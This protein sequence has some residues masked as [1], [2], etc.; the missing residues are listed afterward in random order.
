MPEP[1]TLKSPTPPSQPQEQLSNASARVAPVRALFW[2]A[3]LSV[4]MC[5]VGL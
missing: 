3:V 4:Y 5:A 2:A 1:K